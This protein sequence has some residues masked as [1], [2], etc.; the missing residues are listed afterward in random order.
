ME[1]TTMSQAMQ[2]HAQAIKL[3]SQ[4]HH[5]NYSQ[6]FTFIT[7]SPH[8]NLTYAHKILTTLPGPTTTFYYNTL[9]RAYSLSP[10]PSNSLHLFLSIYGTAPKP[11]KFTYPFVLR[12]CGRMGDARVGRMVHGAVLKAGF[13]RDNYV[14][15]SL[16][17]MY[18]KCGEVG[19]ALKVFDEMPERDVVSWTALVDVLVDS[20]RCWEAIECFGEMRACGVVVNEATVVAVLKACAEAGALEVGRNVH[21]AVEGLGIGE[22]GKV[23]TGLIDMYT[24]CGCVDSAREVFESVVSKDVFCWTAMIHGLASHGMSK[25]A[26]GLFEEMVMSGVEPDERTMTAVLAAC[27]NAGWTREGCV[28]LEE[29]RE[30]YG[31]SPNIQHYGCVV[32]MYARSGRLEEAEDFIRKMPIVPDAVLWRTLIWACK[33]HGDSDRA[34]RLIQELDIDFG[35]CS[36][37]VLISNIYASAGRWGDKAVVRETMSRQGVVKPP[38]TSKIEVDGRVHEFTAGDSNHEEARGIFDKLNEIN[39]RLRDEGYKPVVSE[40][41]LNMDDEEKAFQLLHHS[42]KLAVSFGLIKTEPGSQIRI[43]KNLRSCADCHSFMKVVSRMY[44]REIVV[45]DRIRFHHFRDGE[46]SCGDHW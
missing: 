15:N 34:E 39:E 46:C 1:I 14:R 41:L 17:S 45:R 12:A 24:K 21:G 4:P 30:R 9:I 2:L 38:G 28:Y 13:V 42:E 37:F 32:D 43:V 36:N 35:D 7:L 5:K 19:C 25:E 31:I 29:M 26:V 10:T 23:K 18:G 44:K 27:R 3:N 8:S 11:D 16:V 20:G 22:L 6:L 40:V 33:I